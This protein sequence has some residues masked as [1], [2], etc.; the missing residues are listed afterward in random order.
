MDNDKNYNI[1]FYISG[2][3]A[4]DFNFAIG[5]IILTKTNNTTSYYESA[6][7]RT[8]IKDGNENV[9]LTIEM[10]D[11]NSSTTSAGVLPHQVFLFDVYPIVD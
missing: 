4:T 2:T 5:N 3:N 8:F 11:F 6:L 9:N 7:V 10:Q 1:K